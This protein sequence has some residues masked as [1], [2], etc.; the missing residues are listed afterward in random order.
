MVFASIFFVDAVGSVSL[1]YVVLYVS[2][3]NIRH[4]LAV[5]AMVVGVVEAYVSSRL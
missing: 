4:T 3:T 1:P 2:H 5:V